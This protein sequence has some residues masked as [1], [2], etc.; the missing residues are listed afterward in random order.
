MVRSDMASSRSDI[1]FLIVQTG[2]GSGMSKSPTSSSRSGQINT[3]SDEEYLYSN[4]LHPPATYTLRRRKSKKMISSR[5][6]SS[7]YTNFPLFE[8]L[9]ATVQK[10]S[11]TPIDAAATTK[12]EQSSE[13]RMASSSSDTLTQRRCDDEAR[14]VKTVAGIVESST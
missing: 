5:Q 6:E 11:L 14:A 2:G 1:S 10:R 12:E 7:A 3:D 4:T 13:E 9:S 8:S